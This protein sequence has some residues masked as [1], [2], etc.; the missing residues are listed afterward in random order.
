MVGSMTSRS[1]LL[2][3]VGMVRRLVGTAA[4]LPLTGGAFLLAQVLRAAHRSDLPSFPNQD[5]SGTFGASHLPKLRIVAVGD[6]SL[7]APGVEDPDN[8]WIR[9]LMRRWENRYHIELISL[10]VGG[11][12]ARDVVE[13][14]LA[15]AIRLDPD[16]AVVS[17]CTNDALRGVPPALFTRQLDAIVGGLEEVAAAVVVLGM[18]DPASVPRLPAALRPWVSWRSRVFDRLVVNV[19]NAHPRALKVYSRGRMSSAFF[20]DPTLFAGDQFHAGDG[21]HGV[22]AECSEPAFDAALAMIEAA[23][24]RTRSAAAAD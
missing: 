18:G 10:G 2:R 15:E 23:R 17:V 24:S 11:S 4:A 20:E 14:Q 13:G 8:I 6:S 5:P 16:L 3:T 7:T 12:K 21:G 1:S 22:F 19:A 9:R